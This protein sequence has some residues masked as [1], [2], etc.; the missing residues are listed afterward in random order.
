MDREPYPLPELKYE[1]A[2]DEHVRGI[3]LLLISEEVEEVDENGLEGFLCENGELLL[4][5]EEDAILESVCACSS[6]SRW[7]DDENEQKWK[8]N[9]RMCQ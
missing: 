1:E 3:I 8:K 7:L 5:R 9:N 6:L 4:A 2:D